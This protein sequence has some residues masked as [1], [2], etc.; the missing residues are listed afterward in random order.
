M[1][2]ALSSVRFGWSGHVRFAPR[3]DLA[4]LNFVVRAALLF[5][6]LGAYLS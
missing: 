2:I 6:Y 1:G 3:A 5:G 4:Y